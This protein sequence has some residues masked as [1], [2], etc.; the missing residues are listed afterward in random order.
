MQDNLF[1]R[2][3]WTTWMAKT[4]CNAPL[5]DAC[6]AHIREEDTRYIRIYNVKSLYFFWRWKACILYHCMCL[7]CSASNERQARNFFLSRRG[8]SCFVPRSI[9]CEGKKDKRE[10]SGLWC[11][12]VTPP[13]SAP[14]QSLGRAATSSAPPPERAPSRLLC[15]AVIRLK[16]IYNFWCSMLV[17]TPF[18]YCFVTLSGTFMHFPELTY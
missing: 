12:A 8:A 16:R 18:A 3:L 17:F 5:N 7:A 10:L 1:V 9:D 6:V 13:P 14:H 4:Y 15:L 2:N 11:V